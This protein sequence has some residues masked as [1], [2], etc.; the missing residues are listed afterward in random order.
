M[1]EK[2]LENNPHKFPAPEPV[3]K[4]AGKEQVSGEN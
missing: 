3:A 2:F 1:C 4:K